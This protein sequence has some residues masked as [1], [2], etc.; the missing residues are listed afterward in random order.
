MANGVQAWNNA[1][2]DVTLDYNGSLGGKDQIY[3][4]NDTY[5]ANIGWN[6]RCANKPVHSSGIYKS[7]DIDFNMSTMDNMT[8][9]QRQGVSA[10][11]IEHAL[12]L[13]HVSATN[14]VM[15]TWSGGRTA[16]VPGSDD[17][18]GVNTL[19]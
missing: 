8:N 6:A 15:C 4:Y 2:V 7:S 16:I 9:E 14:Q 13:D 10:H 17:K 5:G 19:Y 12:G 1:G 11:E 18:N 3:F